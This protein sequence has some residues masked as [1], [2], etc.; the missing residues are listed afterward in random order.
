ML[1]NVTRLVARV[2]YLVLTTFVQ[3]INIKLLMTS[4]GGSGEIHQ[5]LCVY[6]YYSFLGGK[7]LKIP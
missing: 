4:R 2:A 3:G 7:T 1:Q 5:L 6:V